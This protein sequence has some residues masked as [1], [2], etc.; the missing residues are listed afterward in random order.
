MDDHKPHTMFR[1]S[2]INHCYWKSATQKAFWQRQ[3]NNIRSST[4]LR[5]VGGPSAFRQVK[6]RKLG[7][8]KWAGSAKKGGLNNMFI[9][10][11]HCQYQYYYYVL[12]INIIVILV[13][14]TVLSL[15][16]LLLLFI[17]YVFYSIYYL[18]LLLF[19]VIYSYFL[20]FIVSYCYFFFKIIIYG[21]LIR[22]YF[23]FSLLILSFHI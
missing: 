14:I 15:L 22:C 10:V 11:Y 4:V 3:K 19:I 13:I 18:Y 5:C 2:H 1:H 23:F 9:I 8:C 6:I 21:Y 16:S 12:L 20:L 17:N 7:S